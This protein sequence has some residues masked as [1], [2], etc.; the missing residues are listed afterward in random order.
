[1]NSFSGGLVNWIIDC[2]CP[3][4]VAVSGS[5]LLFLCLLLLVLF[6]VAAMSVLAP[7]PPPPPPPP[8]HPPPPPQQQQQK[9]CSIIDGQSLEELKMRIAKTPCACSTL[10]S[11]L[12][13]TQEKH[14]S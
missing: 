2:Y 8:H 1:M 13:G 3:H 9:Q 14:S 6:L 11:T 10:D 7:L 5:P 12:R 4:C